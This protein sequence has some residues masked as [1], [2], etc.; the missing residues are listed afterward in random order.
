MVQVTY[1]NLFF[2]SRRDNYPDVFNSLA[3]YYDT[4][5]ANYLIKMVSNL[6]DS[7]M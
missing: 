6:Q 3:P 2:F 1:W 7:L 5:T 4:Y